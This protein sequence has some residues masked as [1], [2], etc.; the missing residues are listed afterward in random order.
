[1]GHSGST[2]L[3]LSLGTMD[4]TLSL[5]EV[6]FLSWQFYQGEIKED[7]QTYCSCGKSFE[8]CEFWAPIFNEISEKNGVNLFKAPHLYD[9]SINRH[10]HRKK[11][12]PVR[13]FF[14]QLITISF[15]RKWLR[16]L[17]YPAYAYFQASV[18]RNWD[19]FDRASKNSGNEFVIDSSKNLN[20]FLL[21]RNKRPKDTKLVLLVRDIRGVCSSSHHGLNDQI[22]KDRAKKWLR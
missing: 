3:D 1:M 18:G 11:T 9:F 10:I 7:P 15:Q 22:V 20:R 12:H 16:F 13:W 2:L 8:S 19:L 5:G 6:Q 17:F 21:L 14:N 4:H